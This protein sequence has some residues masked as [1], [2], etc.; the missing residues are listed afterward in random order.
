MEKWFCSAQVE[1]GELKARCRRGQDSSGISP[2]SQTPACT[3]WGGTR[4]PQC[5]TPRSPPLPPTH[6]A[7]M[8]PES[9]LG[10][11]RY[12]TP[13]GRGGTEPRSPPFRPLLP[14]ADRAISMRV[15]FAF[16]PKRFMVAA[17]PLLLGSGCAAEP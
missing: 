3:P 8:G 1:A 14:S 11:K 10:G 17:F 6:A 12:C 15:S 2:I 16:F 13:G 5:P 9:P 4:A 7:S